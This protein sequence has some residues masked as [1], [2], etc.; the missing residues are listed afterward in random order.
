[1][2]FV[3]VRRRAFELIGYALGLYIKLDVI[4]IKFALMR[5]NQIFPGLPLAFPP[6]SS[7]VIM[8]IAAVPTK[9]RPIIAI[10]CEHVVKL[11]TS[12][13]GYKCH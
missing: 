10:S 8:K 3:W 11:Q 6:Q 12:P 7:S 2:G 1:M 5:T 4:G 13:R 9:S